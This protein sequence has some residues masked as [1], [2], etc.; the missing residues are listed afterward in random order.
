MKIIML[1]GSPRK[2]QSTSHFLLHA[3]KERVTKNNEIIVRQMSEYKDHDKIIE[4][5]NGANAIIVAFPLYVDGIPASLLSVLIEIEKVIKEKVK[6]VVN[7]ENIKAKQLNTKVYAI[8]N[9]GFYDARQNEI[10]IQMV[11]KWCEK[12]GLQKG[13]AIGVG[14]GGMIKMAP[15]GRGP[16]VNLGRAFDKFAEVILD[17]NSCDDIYVEPNFPRFL[18]QIAAHGNWRAAAKRNGLKVG[19]L[20]RKVKVIDS[21]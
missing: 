20:R 17:R 1:C 3:F 8:I 14:A 13:T 4:D 2:E 12:C 16:S 5:M 6:K 15:I 21:I 7:E 10:A 18:Y 9:N 19:E 11:W